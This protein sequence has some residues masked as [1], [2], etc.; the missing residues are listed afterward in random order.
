M[1]RKHLIFS[2]IVQNVGFRYEMSRLA[3]QVGVTG[4]V[5]NQLDG[6]VEAHVQGTPEAI[7][8]MLEALDRIDHIRIEATQEESLPVIEGESSFVTRYFD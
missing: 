7:R 1:I 6:T 8:V 4:W 2:G 5:K 3:Q